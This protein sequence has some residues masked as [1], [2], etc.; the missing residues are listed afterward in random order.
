MFYRCFEFKHV[1]LHML[2]FMM[3]GI[4]EKGKGD[5]FKKEQIFKIH[6]LFIF[7]PIDFTFPLDINFSSIL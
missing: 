2:D 5:S 1:I 4:K 3:Q 7:Y 6:R